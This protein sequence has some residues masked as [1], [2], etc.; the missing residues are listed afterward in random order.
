MVPPLVVSTLDY[1]VGSYLASQGK[2]SAFFAD[3]THRAHKA[4]APPGPYP[5]PGYFETNLWS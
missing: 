5:V 3:A 1:T 2:I 4:P